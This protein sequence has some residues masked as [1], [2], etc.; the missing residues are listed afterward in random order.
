METQAILSSLAVQAARRQGLRDHRLVLRRVQCAIG[1]ALVRRAVR[2]L[3]ARTPSLSEEEERE[4]LGRGGTRVPRPR[5]RRII[6]ADG[7][8]D[9]DPNQAVCAGWTGAL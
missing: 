8:A 5:L 9:A 1:V 3:G 4:L 6:C 2:M 7:E